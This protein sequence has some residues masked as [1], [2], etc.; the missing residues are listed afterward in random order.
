MK[1]EIDLN[2]LVPPEE[3]GR[4]SLRLILHG[5]QVCFARNPTCGRCV[6]R[7]HLPVGRP[8]GEGGRR[9]PPPVAKA[10]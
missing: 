3:R 10:N 1:V 9:R 4:F 5:R 7:R 6:L 2:G 8:R